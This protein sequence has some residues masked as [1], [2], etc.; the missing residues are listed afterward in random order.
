MMQ[1]FLFF[2]LSIACVGC[3]TACKQEEP[4]PTQ[5][6]VDRLAPAM[7]VSDLVGSMSRHPPHLALRER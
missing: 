2:L 4:E 3:L 7:L 1:L 5:P 6:P